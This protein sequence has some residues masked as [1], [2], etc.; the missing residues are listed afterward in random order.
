MSQ[1]IATRTPSETLMSCLTDFGEAE[2]DR[3]L[4]LWTNEA[5]DICWSTSSPRKLS[6]I[7]GMLECAK[8][9]LT[10]EFLELE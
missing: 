10:K 8:A 7:I 3:V 6:A 4:V 9:V 2:P 1:T 5:G